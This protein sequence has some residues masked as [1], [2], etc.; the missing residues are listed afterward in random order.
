MRACTQ[1]ET[2]ACFVQ[3]LC[4]L[5]NKARLR[6]V[7]II[8]QRSSGNGRSHFV[9]D[10]PFRE[11]FVV[12]FISTER[13][14]IKHLIKGTQTTNQRGL[15]KYHTGAFS[16][17]ISRIQFTPSDTHKRAPTPDQ[18]RATARCNGLQR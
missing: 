6:Q 17:R 13:R 1:T 3:V 5:Y 2:H 9:R 7:F 10:T 15:P 18:P 12:C 8:S 4:V 14:A 11:M 16:L